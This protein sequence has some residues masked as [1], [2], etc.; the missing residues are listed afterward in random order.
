[1]RSTVF[2]PAILACFVTA[3]LACGSAAP[4]DSSLGSPVGTAG[5][6]TGG[7]G[8]GPQAGSHQGGAPPQ[9][10]SNSGGFES[11][12][13]NTG[14]APVG[15]PTT[16][17]GAAALKSYVGCD[18]WPTVV[19]NNVWSI[20]DY[21][22][23]VANTS[24]NPATVKVSRAGSDVTS[25]TVAPGSLEKIYLPWV[26]ELK[27]PDADAQGSA[28]PL[29]AT[30]G[31]KGGAYHLVSDLPVTVYQFNALEYQGKGGPPGKNWNSCP[32]KASGIG[33]FSFSNDASILLPSTAMTGNY[34]V[35]APRNWLSSG[36]PVMGGYFA[37]TATQD[38]TKVTVKVSKNGSTLAGAGIAAQKAGGVFDEAMNAG[39]V[40]QIA[41]PAAAGDLSGSLVQA[42]KPVQVIGGIPCTQV[43]EGKQACDHIEETVMPAETLGSHYFVAPMTGPKGNAPGYVVRLYGNFDGTKLTY[44]PGTPQG[45]PSTINAGD[46][47][48]LKGATGT[49]ISAFEVESDKDHP[50]G[51]G[52]YMPGA[53][54][55]DPG[56]VGSEKGDPS[57]SLAVSVEQY[58][59]EYVFLA[60]DD[61]DVS[62]ADVIGPMTVQLT[63]DGAPVSVTPTA[64]ASDVG[65]FRIKLGAGKG[66]AHTLKASA[67]VSLQ[68]MGYGSYT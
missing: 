7:S 48:E 10:G 8:N 24:Q 63:L 21:A 61:Y 39:D 55:L 42:T 1:M 67:P 64:I 15:D 53:S 12:G 54:V 29:G 17:E 62:Y 66:G 13:S 45:A 44:K 27:G 6:G 33:C 3:A 11:G 20:F 65:V 43:P 52:L 36:V 2:V 22:V 26:K 32:G 31:V 23:V 9:G 68:V 41:A 50:F 46:V 4:D 30:V 47:V 58:R 56:N 28:K 34:R 40:V 19:A 59:D 35:F 49:M 25:V 14:G 38:G 57:M 18:Y 37:V 51:V 16:C 5:T 60:P